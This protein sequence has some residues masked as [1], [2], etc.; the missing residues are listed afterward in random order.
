MLGSV[1]F[2]L[3]WRWSI[4]LAHLGLVRAACWD[5]QMGLRLT[6]FWA[7]GRLSFRLGVYSLGFGLFAGCWGLMVLAPVLAVLLLAGWQR[8]LLSFL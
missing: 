5:V 1:F 4:R 8:V 6:L 2:G 3:S 7:R